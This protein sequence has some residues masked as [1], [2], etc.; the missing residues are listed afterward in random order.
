M[1]VLRRARGNM[2]VAAKIAGY[3]RTAF[4]LL[5]KRRAIDWRSFRPAAEEQPSAKPKEWFG[6]PIAADR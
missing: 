6:V 2:T 1:R 4:Y 5:L 3:E